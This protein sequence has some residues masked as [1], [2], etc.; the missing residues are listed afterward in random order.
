[1]DLLRCAQGGQ[2]KIHQL[3]AV[4]YAEENI[5]GFEVVVVDVLPMQPL[6]REPHEASQRCSTAHTRSAGLPPLLAQSDQ[7]IPAWSYSR[8]RHCGP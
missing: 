4:V 6:S 5:V 8:S 3:E 2:A 7:R 1:M